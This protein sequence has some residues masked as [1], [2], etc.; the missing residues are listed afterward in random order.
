MYLRPPV[1]PCG[2]KVLSGALMADCYLEA[3]EKSKIKPTKSWSAVRGTVLSLPSKEYIIHIA[4]STHTDGFTT[5]MHS[6]FMIKEASFRYF[7]HF[8]ARSHVTVIVRHL[9]SETTSC[10]YKINRKQN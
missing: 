7:L 10:S 2:L 4:R 6:D 1:H 8:H 3:A 5:R 9:S